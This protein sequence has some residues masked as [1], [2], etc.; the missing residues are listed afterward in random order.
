MAGEIRD[1]RQVDGRGRLHGPSG[2]CHEACDGGCRRAP[3]VPLWSVRSGLHKP[4]EDCAEANPRL[5][6]TRHETRLD[7]PRSAECAPDCEA[8]PPGWRLEEVTRRCRSP[9]FWK[10]RLAGRRPP[11]RGRVEKSRRWRSAANCH[12]PDQSDRRPTP[13]GDV[14]PERGPLHRLRRV[15]NAL[16]CAG[17]FRESAGRRTRSEVHFRVGP[18]PGDRAS[19]CSHSL[20]FEQPSN[21]PVTRN[22][23]SWHVRH[24]W[25]N[26]ESRSTKW[27]VAGRWR[28]PEMSVATFKATSHS[29]S[30]HGFTEIQKKPSTEP[31]AGG[32]PRGESRSAVPFDL[33]SHGPAGRSFD[34]SHR[35]SR[36]PF[37][38]SRPSPG[39]RS[40]W[41]CESR[42]PDSG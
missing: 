31:P 2:P 21:S 6:T 11:E 24:A 26:R 34:R 14:T 5:A 23:I 41:D 33:I 7:R 20:Q 35:A 27:R 8:G 18:G 22:T 12:G 40:E 1:I 29:P 42:C 39:R 25:L 10:W 16:R 3:K 32:E 17:P 38:S 9:S 37:R 36:S 28:L 19:R 15:P 30:Q 4:I 13:G